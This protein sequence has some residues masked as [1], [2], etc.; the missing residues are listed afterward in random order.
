MT[1]VGMLGMTLDGEWQ[2]KYH[3]PLS[4]IEKLINEFNPDVICGEVHTD[5]WDP[6]IREVLKVFMEKKRA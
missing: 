3:L 6:Y 4:L 5:S 1:A 2:E